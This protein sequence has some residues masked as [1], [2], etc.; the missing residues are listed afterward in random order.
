MKAPM[1]SSA[2]PPL[3]LFGGRMPARL[4]L[5][6]DARPRHRSPWQRPPPSV[7]RKREQGLPDGR[8]RRTEPTNEVYCFL[9]VGADVGCVAVFHGDPFVVYVGGAGLGKPPGDVQQG[10]DVQVGEELALGRMVG[11]SKVEEREDFNRAALEG[12]AEDTQEIVD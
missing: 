4:Q 11:T 9:K 7:P 12:G 2:R 5:L 1:N 6:A 10:R 8:G 3:R